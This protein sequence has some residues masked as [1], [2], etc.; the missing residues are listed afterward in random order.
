LIVMEWV[1]GGRLI[2]LNR[3]RVAEG[4]PLSDEEGSTIMKKILQAVEYIHS[5]NI[6]HRDL[7]PGKL[8]NVFLT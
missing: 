6:L 4:K 3:Q 2:D 1:K 7:K 8:I 5:K